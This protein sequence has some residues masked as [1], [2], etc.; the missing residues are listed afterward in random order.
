MS[1]WMLLR[2]NIGKDRTMKWGLH[3]CI[4]RS[5]EDFMTRTQ[6]IPEI[7]NTLCS[8]RKGET[9]GGDD[10]E[11]GRANHKESIERDHREEH[12]CTAL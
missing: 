5:P 6:E 3:L 9:E 2:M 7:V 8:D 12:K 11:R 10:D 4:C 1:M